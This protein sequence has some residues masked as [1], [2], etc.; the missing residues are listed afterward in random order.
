MNPK[1]TYNDSVHITGE[2]YLPNYNIYTEGPD[3]IR[4]AVLAFIVFLL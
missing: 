3:R 1:V 4:F 2:S